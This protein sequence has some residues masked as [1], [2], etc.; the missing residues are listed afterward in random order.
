MLQVSVRSLQTLSGLEQLVQDAMSTKNLV[1]D[2]QQQEK[3]LGNLY[4]V[5]SKELLLFA[6]DEYLPV[7]SEIINSFLTQV[8]EYQI[9]MKIVETT[10]KLEL[11]AKIFD[12]KGE[13]EVKSLS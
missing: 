9:D 5:L 2:L 4:I 1:K 12:E 11:E 10:E 6:L 7:L 8:V 13:R 3:L